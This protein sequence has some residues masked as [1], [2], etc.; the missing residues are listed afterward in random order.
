MRNSSTNLLERELSGQVL[1]AAIEVHRLL[2]PGLLESAYRACL[3]RELRL[4]GLAVQT[5]VPIPLIY[6]DEQM[7]CGFRIDLLVNEL[8]V[9][10]LKAVEKLLPVHEAR[11]LTY[12]KLC[13]RRI[14]F[15]LNFN[16]TRL[17]SGFRRLVI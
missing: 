9:V 7:G 17:M 4:R 12:L 14:G 1:D 10:E 8:V 5:E 6:K 13:R 16:A 15:L 2:G 11:L 3:A